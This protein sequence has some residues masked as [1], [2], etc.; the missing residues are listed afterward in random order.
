MWLDCNCTYLLWFIEKLLL[1]L[2]LISTIFV[3]G[4]KVKD[5]NELRYL[6]ACIQETFRLTPTI[7][8]L[9]RMLQEDVTLQG[10]S[11]GIL[12]VFPIIMKFN[13]FQV[14]KFLKTL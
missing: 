14:M 13:F 2:S 4:L 8:M 12:L 7:S 9:V 3:G 1:N 6:K 5:L 11:N 10:I